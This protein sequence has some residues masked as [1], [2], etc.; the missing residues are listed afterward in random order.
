[1]NAAKSYM[2]ARLVEASTWRGLLLTLVGLGLIDMSSITIDRL[3]DFISTG[4]ILWGGF[5]IVTPEQE[6]PHD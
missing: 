6:D 1:M 2:L 5:N 4:F 3:A